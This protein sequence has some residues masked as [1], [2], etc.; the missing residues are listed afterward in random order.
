MKNFIL[1]LFVIFLSFSRNIQFDSVFSILSVSWSIGI[2]YSVH[3]FS[4]VSFTLHFIIFFLTFQRF[5]SIVSLFQCFCSSNITLFIMSPTLY[6]Q[7]LTRIAFHLYHRK[8]TTTLII[9]TTIFAPSTLFLCT[10]FTTICCTQLPTIR[11]AR[12]PKIPPPFQMSPPWNIPS[13]F[14]YRPLLSHHHNHHRQ[15]HVD[16]CFFLEWWCEQTLLFVFPP[17]ISFPFLT[18]L[19]MYSLD[20]STNFPYNIFT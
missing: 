18:L 8:Q 5:T 9:V 3:S 11:P 19:S 12:S 4:L 17:L 16:L 20:F 1:F 14:F 7:C 15:H 2:F 6:V 10:T 13:P